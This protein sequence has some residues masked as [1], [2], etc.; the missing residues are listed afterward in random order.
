MIQSGPVATTYKD[1]MWNKDRYSPLLW[2][3]SARS[4]PRRNIRGLHGYDHASS[5]RV[6][7]KT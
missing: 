3:V 1:V 4:T 5:V 2:R 7:C 6:H